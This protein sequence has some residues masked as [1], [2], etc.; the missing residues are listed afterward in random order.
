MVDD[1]IDAE[2]ETRL[3]PGWIDRLMLAA[4]MPDRSDQCGQTIGRLKPACSA[5]VL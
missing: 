4:S 1:A 3:D 5:A 2:V